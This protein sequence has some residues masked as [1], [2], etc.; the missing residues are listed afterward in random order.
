MSKRYLRA[1]KVA[2]RYDTTPT[3]IR[4]WARDPRFAH[5]NFPKSIGIS[6]GVE[7][8]AEDELDAWDQ[9]RI[10]MRDGDRAA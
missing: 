6:D 4:R 10:A 5:L 3:T 8:W 1:A 9:A 2:G 7:A